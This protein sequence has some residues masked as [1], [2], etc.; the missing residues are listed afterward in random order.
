VFGLMAS[1]QVVATHP[2]VILAGSGTQ[3]PGWTGV[4]TTT[5]VQSVRW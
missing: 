2:L 5:W 1:G 3:V 4:W